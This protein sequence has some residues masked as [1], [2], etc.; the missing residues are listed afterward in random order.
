V[1]IEKSRALQMN[2]H[3]WDLNHKTQNKNCHT[4]LSIIII[5]CCKACVIT[6]WNRQPGYLK[7][8]SN[9]QEQQNPSAHHCCSS[10]KLSLILVSTIFCELEGNFANE[11]HYN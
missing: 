3:M 9:V 8:F 2:H 5:G 6:S 4:P 10:F 11:I 1:N 7:S